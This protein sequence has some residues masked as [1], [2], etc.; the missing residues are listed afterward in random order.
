MESSTPELDVFK[1]KGDGKKLGGAGREGLAVKTHGSFWKLQE[2]DPGE[3]VWERALGPARELAL[4]LSVPLYFRICTPPVPPVGTS[5]CF[6]FS[7]HFL[8][9]SL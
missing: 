3:W 1:E 8:F 5:S 6:K 2:Q 7:K 4:I 9:S